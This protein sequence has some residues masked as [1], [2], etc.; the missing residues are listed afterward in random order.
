[1]K[2]KIIRLEEDLTLFEFLYKKG[3]VDKKIF[4]RRKK[5]K[6]TAKL[7]IYKENGLSKK[8]KELYTRFLPTDYC[9]YI[10]YNAFMENIILH[11]DDELEKYPFIKDLRVIGYFIERTEDGCYKGFNSLHIIL[12]DSELL[13]NKIIENNFQ[14]DIEVSGNLFY[15]H[16]LFIKIF[17][18]TWKN[19]VR[20]NL[21]IDSPDADGEKFI[22]R[23]LIIQN[24]LYDDIDNINTD[25]IKT[26]IIISKLDFEEAKVD[27]LLPCDVDTLKEACKN[28]DK[29]RKAELLDY[30]L[31]FEQV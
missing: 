1:M 8:S 15:S 5:W 11:N 3:Y 6:E 4:P 2:K 26:N 22:E 19:Y 28:A 14:E 16:D 31:F 20:F 12:E 13:K 27:L 21:Y 7:F 29:E 25:L 10:N 24:L 18:N 30:V 17:G 9:R 23:D